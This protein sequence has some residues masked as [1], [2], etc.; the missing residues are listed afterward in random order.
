MEIF[1]SLEEAKEKYP[2]GYV[3]I[4][5]IGECK[6]CKKQED[7]RCGVCYGCAFQVD[8]EVIENGHRL[9]DSV[10]PDNIW[11]VDSF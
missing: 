5:S 8:G 10:N 9:W 6:I 3:A 2:D 4:D 1:N 11:Y 7:L